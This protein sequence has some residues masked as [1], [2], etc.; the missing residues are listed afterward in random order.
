[1]WKTVLAVWGSAALAI[2]AALY[3]THDIRCLWFLLV[4]MFMR[5]HAEDNKENEDEDGRN[6]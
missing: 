3:F 6:I 1:M 5:F 2:A 4:P